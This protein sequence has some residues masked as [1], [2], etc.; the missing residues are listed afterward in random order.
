MLSGEE[1]TY[2]NITSD[3]FLWQLEYLVGP[4]IGSHALGE[5]ALC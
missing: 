5:P 3:V 4:H 1:H 2:T